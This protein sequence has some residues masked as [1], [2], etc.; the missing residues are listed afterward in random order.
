MRAL[1]SAARL[2]GQI[3]IPASKSEAHR[4]LIA[5]AL[6]DGEVAISGL[7]T[8]DDIEKTAGAL[9][10]L[11]AEVKRFGALTVVTGIKQAPAKAVI[12]CGESGSTLRFMLP[13]AAVLGVETAFILHGRL[14]ERPLD[15]MTSLLES[16]GVT[17]SR[18]D[19]GARVHISGR[20][21][22]KA[23][24]IRGDVCSQYV[25]GLMFAF[26]AVGGG[27][28]HLTT[29]LQSAAYVQ[30]TVD[31]LARFG[32][33]VSLEDST[34]TVSGRCKASR[35]TVGGDWSQAAFWLSAAAIGADIELRGL[36]TSSTQG[37]R[38]CVEILRRMGCRIEERGG[39]LYACAGEKLVA[40]DID[41]AQI[42]DIIPPLA[43]ACAFAES[44]SRIFN[45]ARLRIKESDRLEAMADGLRRMGIECETSPDTLIIKG[46][47]PKSASVNGCND[48]RIVMAFSV[49]ASFCDGESEISDAGAINKSYP[50]FFEDLKKLGGKINVI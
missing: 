18:S 32:V 49:A 22:L 16:G 24:R 11:G 39:V 45:A 15:D 14:A 7:T 48:H 50:T 5:A 10:A 1:V 36:N 42:P 43:V 27:Q 3:D 35:I 30:M 8:S 33:T 47:R 6:S 12:D 34:Y 17:C 46:G 23:A 21:G 29:G 13:I 31:T 19:G 41:A 4:A 2:K 28:I 26:A 20:F 38:E 37:D 40:T 25:T 9:A 44:E